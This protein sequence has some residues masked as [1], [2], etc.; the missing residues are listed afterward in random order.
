MDVRLPDGR[1]LRNVP[2]GTTKAQIEAKLG[3]IQAAPA[4]APQSYDPTEGM[5]GGEKF[6]AGMGKAFT[7]VGRGVGNLV[8]LVSDEDVAEA[9]RLDAPLMDT[10]AGTAGNVTGAFA[11]FL[12]LMAVPGAN[13]LQ[14]AALTSALFSAA[15]TPGDLKERTKAG[16]IG[17]AAGA[18]GVAVAK[19]VAAGGRALLNKATQKGAQAAATNSVKDAT[20]AAARSEG[21]VLPPA[22]SNPTILNRVLSGLGGKAS[23]EQRASVAN[24]E[25]TNNLS[26]KAIGLPGKGPIAPGELDAVKAP[27]LQIYKDAKALGPDVEDAVDL[28]RQAN[29]DAQAYA[30]FYA[31]TADPAAQKAAQKAASEASGWHQFIE[32]RAIASGRPDLAQ[33]LSQA[34][35]QL[36]KIGTVERAV[37]ESTGNVSARELGKRV[38]AGKPT[39]GELAE[40]GRTA[41][42]YPKSLQNLEGMNPNNLGSPLD[43]AVGAGSAVGSGNLLALGMIGARPVLRAGLLSK[44]YQSLSAVPS[45]GPNALSRGAVHAV[46]NS[47]AQAAIRASLPAYIARQE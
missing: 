27:V 29:F 3:K 33:A 18:G 21:Y 10:G 45:Y 38:A 34:R 40:I 12:P 31:R 13:T 11:T 28:W 4:P 44:P 37:N 26:R 2:E 16:A 25:V 35:V 8:G 47:L 46:E 15:T 1:I 14:G 42:A 5:S 20:T 24:Q 17:G 22:Q 6:L 19:G 9:R 30:K 32:Q 39:T 23:I 36:G 43:W 7:D 41:N